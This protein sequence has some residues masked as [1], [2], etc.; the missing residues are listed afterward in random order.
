[1]VLL[2]P[3][4]RY[5]AELSPG[6]IALWCYAIWYL[7]NV[8]NHFDPK[9]RLWLTSIGL[10]VIIGFG[11]LL[12]T[13]ASDSR[14]ITLDRWVVFRLFLMPFCV[15]SFGA[16]IKDAGYILIFPPSIKENLIGLAFISAF[17]FIVWLAKAVQS[18]VRTQSSV[19]GDLVS[20]KT[21][22][23]R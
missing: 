1:M 14:R 23:V 17:L 19:I 2:A 21:D 18:N 11:L 7:L 15:S 16:L 9:P 10:S 13:T 12:S 5:L 8:W 20:S 22:V 3:I 4:R 6:R